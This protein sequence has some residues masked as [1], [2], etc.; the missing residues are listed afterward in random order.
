MLDHLRDKASG[1]KVRLF[2]CACCRRIWH[3]LPSEACKQA[4]RAA[5]LFADG[6]IGEEER[7]GAARG[8]A[9]AYVCSAAATDVT[10]VP[11]TWDPLDS[12]GAEHPREEYE[13]LYE[14]GCEEAR[15]AP[16]DPCEA[17]VS[18]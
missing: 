2:A 5:E 12:L 18:R 6:L 16:G 17:W 7:R 11:G 9:A 1:R 4:V 10:G 8:A 14:R 13:E 3:L 15:L